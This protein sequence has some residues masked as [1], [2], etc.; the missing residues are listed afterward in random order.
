MQRLLAESVWWFVHASL[1]TP[2]IAALMALMT[3]ELYMIWIESTITFRKEYTIIISL[4]AFGAT[5]LA[6]KAY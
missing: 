6:D 3:I 4:I 5:Y 2:F 1:I